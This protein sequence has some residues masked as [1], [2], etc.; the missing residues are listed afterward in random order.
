MSRPLLHCRRCDAL[1]DAEWCDVTAY[2]DPEPVYVLARAECPTAG[3]V[4]EDGSRAVPPPDVPGQ[5]T[6][7]D[8]RWL[9]RQRRVA[10]EL[11]ELNR[12]LMEA[13]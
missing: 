9:R 5:L 1:A 6:H 11:G 7:E 2:G 13:L 3:C 10:D 4:D 12:R 8:Q